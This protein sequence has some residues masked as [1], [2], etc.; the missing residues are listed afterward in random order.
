MLGITV[1]GNLKRRLGNGTICPLLCIYPLIVM[2]N[3]KEDA[4][5]P[6]D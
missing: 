2:Y 6:S 3:F 4:S 1:S 5:H